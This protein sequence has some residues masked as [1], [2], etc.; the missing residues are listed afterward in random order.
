MR[1]ILIYTILPFFIDLIFWGVVFFVFK[2]EIYDLVFSVFSNIPF[3][4]V[5]TTISSTIVILV[6]Y[7]VLVLATLGIF[8]SFFI[9]KIV[10]EINKNYNCPLKKTSFKDTL[11]GLFLSIKSFLIYFVIFIFTFWMLFIPVL[12]VIYQ[13]VM[14]YVLNKR[15]LIFDSTYLFD[16][17]LQKVDFIIFLTSFIYLI[18]ILSLFGYTFQLYFVT[19]KQL[20]ACNDLSA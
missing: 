10:L 5:V 17:K 6:L 15:V 9:D 13:V 2:E 14:M 11:K 7:Y 8:S 20:K 12:N 4:N 16:I 18:P 19:K 1:K 3:A